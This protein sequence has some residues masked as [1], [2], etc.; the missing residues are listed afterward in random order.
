MWTIK[1]K[2]FYIHGYCD[3]TVCGVTLDDNN[4]GITFKS[5]HAAKC[6]ISKWLNKGL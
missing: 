2:G 4:I 1:Y 5:L 6:G 3:K